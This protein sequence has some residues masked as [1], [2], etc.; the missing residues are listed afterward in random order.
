MGIKLAIVGHGAMGQL[1]ERIALERGHTVVSIVDPKSPKAT[2]QALNSEALAGAELAIDFS[3]PANIL[4]NI[5]QYC[6]C[7]TSAVI[8]VTGWYDKLPSVRKQ[9][10]AAGIGFLWGSN[11]SIGVNLYFKVIEDAAKRFAAIEEY[12]VWGSELHH[13]GKADSPSGT[14]R[15]LTEILIQNIPRKQS[16][17]FEML[18]RRR[19]PEE[20][21]F[22]SVRGGPVNFEHTVCFDSSADSIKITHAARDRSGY[23]LGA[24]RA[25]EWLQQQRPGYFELSDFVR[26]LMSR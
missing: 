2:N 15:T 1:I 3:L 4:S 18:N 26:H 17:V 8:G 6:R 24:V 19:A 5:E 21:H 12:D 16:A 23:A 25:G 9:V 7:K 20:L 22:S 13:A 11:F 14:A 10:E